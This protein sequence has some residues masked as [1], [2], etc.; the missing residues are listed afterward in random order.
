M[1]KSKRI[2]FYLEHPPFLPALVKISQ[3][4]KK[5]TKEIKEM[6]GIIHEWFSFSSEIVGMQLMG[7]SPPEMP[8][9]EK[10]NALYG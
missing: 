7:R 4:I 1:V 9:E 6:K 8:T 5:L 10:K 3:N 2:E